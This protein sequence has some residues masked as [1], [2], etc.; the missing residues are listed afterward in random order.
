L[1]AGLKK[2]FEHF[3]SRFLNR[4]NLRKKVLLLYLFV[5]VIPVILLG[6]V[7]ERIMF[8]FLKSDYSVSVN[9]AVDQV[10]KN[11]E[12]RKLTYELLV[13]RTAMDGELATRLSQN[14]TDIYS[15]WET[16]NYIDRSFGTVRDTLP[17]VQYF[18][19]YHDNDT[20]VEDGG[21]LW[22]PGGRS[23]TDGTED[24]WY[25]SMRHTTE[26]MI[27][28]VYTD[29]G[30]GSINLTLSRKINWLE[31]DSMSGA[32]ILSIRSGPVFENLLSSAFHGQGDVF[33]MN[34][35]GIIFSSSDQAF[36]G[37]NA[38]QTS[39]S[40]IAEKDANMNTVMEFE[41]SR[42][43]IVSRMVASD[44]RVVAA[45]PL[46]K[47]ENRT[48]L[49]SFWMIVITL[50]LVLLSAFLIL[51]VINNVVS[52]LKSLENKMGA[53]TKGKFNVAV[54]EGYADELGDLEERFNIMAGRLGDLTD[55]IALVRTRE[56]EEALKA[57]QAQIN[58]HFLYNTLG[59]I[60][61]RALDCEDEELR[62]LVDAMTVFY[63]L[64]LNKGNSILRIRDEI[65]HVKAYIEIQQFRY[66]N[67]VSVQWDID[68]SAL[69]LYTIKLTL[70]P[71]VENSYMHGMVAKRGRGT[72]DISVAREGE[73]V[74]FRIRDNGI[75]IPENDVE[76]LLSETSKRES[77]GYGLV[78]IGQRLRLYFGDRGRL[79][80][81]SKWG[82]GTAVTIVIPACSEPPRLK[83]GNDNA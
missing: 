31:S 12:F 41:G 80:L 73:E 81:E 32:I 49:L 4:L 43:I 5:V 56:R 74:L 27:W 65:D 18:R 76:R 15:Q 34:D 67:N 29:R 13:T 28:D 11:V 23:L 6:V 71:V 2:R 54:P 24:S 14:Y 72:L 64:S 82:E 9:E 3:A 17:G 26:P 69:E 57:L 42:D 66:M 39:L 48:R 45:I 51:G 35:K 10:V 55:E 37:K 7:A 36:I 38:E 62:R 78:N 53:V 79:F 33:L 75:G 30:N 60:R 83:E 44:W 19:I 20:L 16:V 68:P 77:N 46:E 52:R 21:F 47:L 40:G 8:N 1:P 63:R 22:K 61:W 58:P 25:E 50:S 70:Q 59:I